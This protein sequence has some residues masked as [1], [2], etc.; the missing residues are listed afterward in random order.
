MITKKYKP[1][2]A[3]MLGNALESYDVVLY[4][5]FAAFLAPLFFPSQNHMA[6]NLFAMG[7]FALGFVMRPLGGTIFGII[8]DKWG[9]KSALILSILLMA[10]PTFIIGLLPTYAQIGMIAPLTLVCCLLLQ[11]ACAGGAYS[12][13]AVFINEHSEQGRAG[14]A[15]S[16]L[17]TSGFLGGLFVTGLGTLVSRYFL[18]TWA[19]RIPFIVGGILG[20]IIYFLRNMFPESPAFLKEKASGHISKMPL[21]EV[22]KSQR[23]NVL[24]TIGLGGAAFI[25]FY[26]ISIY[27]NFFLSKTLHFLPSD[28]LELNMITMIWWIVCLPIWGY[29]SD[30]IGHRNIMLLSCF[31]ILLIVYPLFSILN[32]HTSFHE[33]MFIQAIISI[34]AS[35]FVAPSS[36]FLTSLFPVRSRSSGMSFSYFLGASLFAGTTPL[37]DTH[38]VNFTGSY[39]SPAYYVI[40]GS[41]LGAICVYKARPVGNV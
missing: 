13:A 17:N 28:I 9:R 25:P 11:G 1:V 30:K 33:C 35:A 36:A 10:I 16:M 24:C 12:G 18:V 4:G 23:G 19:W 34:V 5:Y 31:V 41:I 29:I 14:F 39:A 2:I 6:S 32:E 26:T 15:G 22:L 38:L 20:F 37:I 21:I 40:F 8:G 7:S 27:F 3:A